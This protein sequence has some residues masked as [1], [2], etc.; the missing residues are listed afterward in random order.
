L[1]KQIQKVRVT[2]MKLSLPLLVLA[3]SLFVGSPIQAQQNTKTTNEWLQFR[4]PNGTGV[5][6]GFTLPAELGAT[7]N[8]VWKTTVPFARSS[9]VVTSDRI[10]L[11]ASEGDKLVT[12]ALDR[13]TG[14][15]LWRRDVARARHMPIYKANDGASPTPV[16]DG[17]NVFVFFAELGLISYAP[18]GKERW[19]V[20]L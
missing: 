3:I 1:G 17:K 20:P 16:S 18:D 15:I 12:L 13:K 7:K 11:T 9:P 6:D 8:V 2:I 14:K 4:G 10:F 19:R 5:A